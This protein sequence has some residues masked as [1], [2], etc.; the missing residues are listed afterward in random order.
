MSLEAALV[1]SATREKAV[2][3]RM[4]A[5]E[6]ELADARRKVTIDGKVQVPLNDGEG[7]VMSIRR[8]NSSTSCSGTL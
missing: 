8:T 4:E 5:L 1:Q 6:L 7:G 2:Q 3:L